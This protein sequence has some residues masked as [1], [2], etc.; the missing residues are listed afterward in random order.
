MFGELEKTEPKV[1]SLLARGEELLEKSPEAQSQGLKQNLATLRARWENI[2]S[3]AKDRKAKL[4]EAVNKA[5]SFHV[6][7]CD[8]F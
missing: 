5:D 2:N 6:G 3:R 4:E 7:K 1:D 8:L